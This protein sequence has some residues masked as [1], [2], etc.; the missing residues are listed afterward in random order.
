MC[1]CNT[2]YIYIIGEI[3]LLSVKVELKV[4]VVFLKTLSSTHLFFG[5]VQ[6]S[7]RVSLTFDICPH[8]VQGFVKLPLNIRQLFKNFAGWP[9]QHL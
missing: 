5:H 6:E 1:I 3:N 8:C 7:H 2:F 9:Q 4:K